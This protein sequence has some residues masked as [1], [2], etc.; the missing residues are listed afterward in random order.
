MRSNG[1]STSFDY[2]GTGV[3]LT[4]ATGINDLGEI[5]GL[6]VDSAGNLH[7]FIRQP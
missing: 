7:G 1:T 4:Q 5:G 2:P 3:V 6:F